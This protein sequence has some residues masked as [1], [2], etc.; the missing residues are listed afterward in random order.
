MDGREVGSR[1]KLEHPPPA[2]ILAMC[3]INIHSDLN[4]L[5]PDFD[6]DSPEAR[7]LPFSSLLCKNPTEAS[8]IDGNT[9]TSAAR[10]KSNRRSARPSLFIGL[11]VMSQ[12]LRQGSFSVDTGVLVFGFSRFRRGQRAPGPINGDYSLKILCIHHGRTPDQ[13]FQSLEAL[14]R[15]SENQANPCREDFSQSVLRSQSP[16]RIHHTAIRTSNKTL[17][18]GTARPSL[19]EIKFLWSLI[20]LLPKSVAVQPV[21]EL[22]GGL[23]TTCSSDTFTAENVPTRRSYSFLPTCLSSWDPSGS[24]ASRNVALQMRSNRAGFSIFPGTP[25][26]HLLPC[27]ALLPSRGSQG[28]SGCPNSAF[29]DKSFL[30]VPRGETVARHAQ[31]RL[32][33]GEFA[34]RILEPSPSPSVPTP[35]S[36]ADGEVY[37][38]TL[39]NGRR[40]PIV[41]PKFDLSARTALFQLSLFFPPSRD[42]LGA[43]LDAL[44]LAHLTRSDST[45]APRIGDLSCPIFEAGRRCA[46]LLGCGLLCFA[47]D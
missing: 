17:M 36:K 28:S 29:G 31:L 41:Q 21:F 1:Q 13:S 24:D 5:R 32:S 44:S 33:G 43:G 6:S 34:E 18:Q 15:T 8:A 45:H 23:A 10:R 2:W 47:L 7:H 11:S 26:S 27:W 37:S 38:L 14:L 25:K 40:L 20:L 16:L 35:T 19:G 42:D 46:S 4:R 12:S 9:V 39:S 30:V 22:T 3:C